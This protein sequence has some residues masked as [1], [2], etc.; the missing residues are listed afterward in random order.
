MNLIK[1]VKP[2]DLNVVIVNMEMVDVP[3]EQNLEQQNIKMLDVPDEMV[4]LD[5]VGLKT[6]AKR[7]QWMS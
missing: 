1:K 7:P 3:S 6:R 2:R 4:I 5:I